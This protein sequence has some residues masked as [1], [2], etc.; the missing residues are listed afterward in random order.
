MVDKLNL[1]NI[2]STLV[3]H[4]ILFYSIVLF[5]SIDLNNY[6]PIKQIQNHLE[7]LPS[8]FDRDTGIILLNVFCQDFILNPTQKNLYSLQLLYSISFFSPTPS[9]SLLI[10]PPPRWRHA[11]ASQ[12]GGCGGRTVGVA[13]L[14]QRSG[15]RRRRRSGSSISSGSSS[16][17]TTAPAPGLCFVDVNELHHLARKCGRIY[18]RCYSSSR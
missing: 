15:R 14:S 11:P 1:N 13:A 3:T 17:A 18:G 12:W 6:W 5:F 7:S 9:Y 8:L 10:S 16:I 4:L 2:F